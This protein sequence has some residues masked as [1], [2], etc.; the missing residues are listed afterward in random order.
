MGKEFLE[1]TEKEEVSRII[2]ELSAKLA[3]K[4]A[5]ATEKVRVDSGE[6]LGRIASTDFFSPLDI[7]PFDRA[8]MDGYA[9]LAS[10]TFYAAE[11][12]PASLTV[13][14]PVRPYQQ[15]RTQLLK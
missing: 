3:D 12:N 14:L 5:A 8:T 4:I 11:D 15:E 1:I 7:P 10:D 9:V 13:N 6:A 2:A